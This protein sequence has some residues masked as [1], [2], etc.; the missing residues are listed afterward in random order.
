MSEA[1]KQRAAMMSQ[2]IDAQAEQQLRIAE[3]KIESERVQKRAQVDQSLH[4]QSMTLE[5]QGMA[6]GMQARQQSI[7]H[8]AYVNQQQRFQ[9]LGYGG[10]GMGGMGGFP[11]AFRGF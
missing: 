9:G 7:M 6:M 3:A 10:Y 8:E 4:V 5:Q 11:G 2:M 1:M